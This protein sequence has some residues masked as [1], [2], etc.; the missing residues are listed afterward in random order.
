MTEIMTL[1][2]HV[3]ILT[4][5]TIDFIYKRIYHPF[6]GFRP[7]NGSNMKQVWMKRL[8]YD[9]SGIKI[10]AVVVALPSHY[11]VVPN[12]AVQDENYHCKIL[13]NTLQ[14]LNELKHILIHS[15]MCTYIWSFKILCITWLIIYQEILKK[16]RD[17]LKTYQLSI[18]KEIHRYVT[19]HLS[20]NLK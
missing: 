18:Q 16:F 14:H 1:H 17:F 7:L 3:Y 19:C 6:I 12:Y 20:S 10:G 13:D 11:R 5:I 15:K 2:N 8:Y 9:Y 4:K